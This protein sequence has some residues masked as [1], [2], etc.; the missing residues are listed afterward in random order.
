MRRLFDSSRTF[1]FLAPLA[2]AGGDNGGCSSSK[3]EP[4][5]AEQIRTEI[6]GNTFRVEG[7]EEFAFVG[8][9]GRMG[10]L[11]AGDSGLEKYQGS[12]SIDETNR[13]CVDWEAEIDQRDNCA[14][15]KPLGEDAFNWGG[16]TVVKLG[17]GTLKQL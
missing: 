2:M 9:D 15:V 17:P 8:P 10:G 13:L 7:V 5:S 16:R 4:F 3:V 11:I 12:W 14:T 1:I 6:V